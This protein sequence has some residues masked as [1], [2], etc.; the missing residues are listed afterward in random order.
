MTGKWIYR[1]SLRIAL[2]SFAVV[3]FFSDGRWNVKLIR[4]PSIAEGITRGNNFKGMDDCLVH[5]S[6][7]SQ[8]D[9]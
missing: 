6:K 9:I 7:S 3:S 4:N 8:R 5:A 1:R 2:L